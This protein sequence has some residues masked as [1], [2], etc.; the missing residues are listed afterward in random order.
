MGGDCRCARL[1]DS[2]PLSEPARLDRAEGPRKIFQAYPAA[3]TA[4]YETGGLYG[5]SM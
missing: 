5:L 4:D 3:R 2:F 1:A